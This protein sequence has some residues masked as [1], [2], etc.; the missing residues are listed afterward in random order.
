MTEISI[1][2]LSSSSARGQ[3]SNPSQTELFGIQDPS[4]HV[5]SMEGQGAKPTIPCAHYK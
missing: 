5:K 3:S 4:P 2:Q 1:P